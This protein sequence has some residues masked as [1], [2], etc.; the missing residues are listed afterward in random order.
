MSR[1]ASSATLLPPGD[2]SDSASSVSS[3]SSTTTPPASTTTNTNTNTTMTALVDA[4]AGGLYIPRVESSLHQFADSEPQLVVSEVRTPSNFVEEK[5]A[6]NS[7]WGIGDAFSRP[8]A[9]EEKD[10]IQRKYEELISE[11]FRL[12]L[13]RENNPSYKRKTQFGF[14]DLAPLARNAVQCLVQD[15]FTKCFESA[16]RD[17]WNWNFYLFPIY[18]LGVFF[19]YFILFPIRLICL[20]MG[21]VLF[22]LVM[23]LTFL[24][25]EARRSR[26]QQKCVQLLATVFAMSWTAVIRYHG[27]PPPRRANQIFVANHT[28][29]IDVIVLMQER[30]YSIVGQQHVGVV[31]FC[32]KYVLGSMRNLWFDRMAAKDRATV[33]SHLHEHIQDPTNPPLLLFPEGTCVNNEYVV[34]FKR[35]AFDL[36]ATVIPIAIKYN[37]IFVDAFW[38]SRIQSFPQH[39]FRLMTSWCVVADVWFLEPQTKLPTESS[40]QFASRVKE[41]ICKQAGLVSVAWDGY[42]KHV[43]PNVRD[44]EARQKIFAHNLLFRFG[45]NP[46]PAPAAAV[47]PKA[48]ATAAT[49]S[50]SS[51]PA[52]AHTGAWM[53]TDGDVLPAED[54]KSL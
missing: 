31:A 42:L 14:L 49:S 26:Y 4:P 46:K 39:L 21:F 54:K 47:A 43:K 28:S 48:Q 13:T 44:K 3:S 38:N 50:S 15:D 20:I 9:A 19:R 27:T 5:M 30:P 16:R 6:K 45:M 10:A 25:P 23:P 33:A 2:A 24:L 17:P 1:G 12:Q 37:K 41:L 32:Q 36:N 29:L 11:E 34:M 22:A 8:T 40:T 53:S 7:S 35:G 18:Y 52:D 51:R